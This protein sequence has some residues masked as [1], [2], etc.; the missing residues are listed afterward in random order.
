MKAKRI[1]SLLVC[2]A[3]VLGCT[4][5]ASAAAPQG[6][7]TIKDP[8]NSSAT[9]SG[10]SF[11]IYQ[12]FTAVTNDGQTS[13]SWAL[14]SQGAPAFYDF[15][16]GSNDPAIR[17]TPEGNILEAVEYV[18][19]Q[20]EDNGINFKLSQLAEKLHNYIEAQNKATAGLIAPVETIKKEDTEGK[21]S[22]TVDGLDY[23]YYLIY[24]SA[25]LTG[26]AVR[27]AV[28]LSNVTKDAEVTLKANRPQ[29]A[30]YVLEND[31]KTYGK[32]T[33]SIIGEKSEFK[34]ELILPSRNLYETYTYFVEDTLPD[35]MELDINSIEIYKDNETT[36]IDKTGYTVTDP[37][38]DA[39]FKVDLTTLISD[40]DAYPA[41][42][43]LSILYNATVNGKILAG[44]A[45]TNIAKLSYSN[46]PAKDTLG[47]V[48]DSASIFTYSFVLTKYSEDAHGNFSTAKRLADATFKIYKNGSNDPINFVLKPANEVYD[49]TE[50]YNVYV[51]ATQ[52]EIEEGT[53]VNTLTTLDGTAPADGEEHLRSTCI[54]GHLGD[55]TV[56]G[57][58]EGEYQ[59]EETEAPEGYYKA[60]K[61]I[62]FII[63][64]TTDDTGKVSNLTVNGVYEGT[65]GSIGNANGSVANLLT[66]I[67]FA[68]QPGEALPETGG[69]GTTLFTVLGI[70]MMAG[71]VA[72]FTSRKR[73]SVA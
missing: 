70:V 37:D 21:T 8:A 67:D 72:F 29:M 71:A 46:D 42:T 30:K 68:D 43:K 52:K 10:K 38:G 36:P 34:I 5:L 25:D 44:K 40:K 2:L 14:N 4:V 33:S 28:M 55:F 56:F 19:N 26:G 57:L 13:Y 51:V 69:M 11:D 9:I 12:V 24:D 16:F 50:T 31:G 15:F 73:S 39:D 62:T 64:D 7:I 45:N 3:L 59:I 23:G 20:K 27:S 58:K 18:S 48:T 1:L 54:G 66:W 49:T 41:N 17:T 53:T 47:S 32:A 63:S 60:D 65:I 6:S 35:S 61:K 22:I